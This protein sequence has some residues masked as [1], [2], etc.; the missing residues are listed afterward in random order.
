M[1]KNIFKKKIEKEIVN[2][3]APVIESTPTLKEPQVPKPPIIITEAQLIRVIQLL[4]NSEELQLYYK[5][6]EGQKVGEELQELMR[7]LPPELLQ[8]E[9]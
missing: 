7:L 2:I 1:I 5:A 3:E 8:Q 4:E 9:Q 6:I